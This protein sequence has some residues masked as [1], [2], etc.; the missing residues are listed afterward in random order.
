MGCY[1]R[2]YSRLENEFDFVCTV[3]FYIHIF[4]GDDK[5]RVQLLLQKG[6]IYLGWP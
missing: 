4:G 5:L 6:I 3:F 1:E 2:D